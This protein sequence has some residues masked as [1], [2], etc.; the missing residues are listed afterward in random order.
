MSFCRSLT[1]P[2]HLFTEAHSW[3]LVEGY[4]FIGGYK[5]INCK[6]WSL[7]VSVLIILSLSQFYNGISYTFLD[8]TMIIFL[9][10]GNLPLPHKNPKH[11]GQ[12]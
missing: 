8:I 7:H 12:P 1:S 10:F 4:T 11:L 9:G 5:H 6:V 3:F 2:L